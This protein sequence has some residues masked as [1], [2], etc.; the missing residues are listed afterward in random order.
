M[1]FFR[2]LHTGRS[3]I[4]VTNCGHIVFFHIIILFY[5]K[6]SWTACYLKVHNHNTAT[7]EQVKVIW[8]Q[9]WW[10]NMGRQVGV[11]WLL[12]RLGDCKIQLLFFFFYFLDKSFQ[13]KGL[14]CSDFVVVRL[15]CCNKM[16]MYFKP[17]VS[18]NVSGAVW[19]LLL[20]S[21]W[22]LGLTVN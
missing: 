12:W 6:L 1:S 21:D 15:Y 9:L 4:N 22:T 13:V 20:I 5:T 17:G 14:Y 2:T 11:Y 8:L 10:Q 16:W 19:K 18:L 3:V 7:V